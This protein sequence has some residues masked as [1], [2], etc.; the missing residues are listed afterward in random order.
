MSLKTVYGKSKDIY[1]ELINRFPLRRLRT[2][3]ELDEAIAVIDSLLDKD[4][5]NRAEED[6]LDA[7]SDFVHKYETE[8]QQI[9]TTSDAEVLRHLL[10]SQEVTQADV[11]K[12]TRIAESTIS[13]VLSGKRTLNRNHIAKLSRY[14][15]VEPSVF[16][17]E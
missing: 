3:K 17:F 15:H 16:S 1:L 9:P 14:F 7:L 10:E 4:T 5:L 12:A 6:Y 2:E 13:E 11:A 8:E